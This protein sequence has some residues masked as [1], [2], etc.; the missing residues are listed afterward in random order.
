MKKFKMPS[1]YTILFLIIIIIALLTWIVPSGEYYNKC[2]SGEEALMYVDPETGVENNVCPVSKQAALEL[3]AALTTNA[4]V[5]SSL[6]TTD[7]E[8]VYTEKEA[9]PQGIW[10]VLSAPINGFYDAVDI[11]LFVLIIGGFINVVM[12]TGALTEGINALL[13]KFK[14]REHFLIPILMTLFALLGT[15]M[16]M[17][18]ETIAFYLL[19]VPIFYQA[20]YDTI[21]GVK[22]ILLGAGVGVLASTVNPFAIGVASAAAGTSMGDG[23][24][25]RTLLWVILLAVAIAYTMR[26]AHKVKTDPSKSIVYDLKE[27]HQKEFVQK[28]ET[29]EELTIHHKVILALFVSSFIVMVLSVIPWENFGVT[30]FATI[31]T[32]INEQMTVLSGIDGI[33]ILGAWW[34]GELTTLFLTFAIIV[35]IYATKTKILKK[36]FISAF[37]AGA[38]DLLPVALIVG[39]S[40]GIQVVMVAGGMDATLLYYGSQS[41]Q[42]LG[43]VAFSI[44]SFIFYIPMSFL[45]PSTSGLAGATIPVMSPLGNMIFDS[46]SGSI[47]VITGY[48]M[49]S[50]I[51]N[52][53]T[54][55]SGVVMGGLALARVP[56][57]RWLK[58]MIPFI[59]LLTIICII[60]LTIT[61]MTGF[62]L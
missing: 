14:N 47:Q 3:N 52:L 41:L 42:N 19:I 25:G 18:E 11:G 2:S 48:I 27:E 22:V 28:E 55:T 8:Y 59:I 23:I 60:F 33:P 1:S 51:V 57:D 26:Y 37:I 30:I 61:T 54:P 43:E 62:Y 58:H 5:D 21:T 24:V 13:R 16:G 10:A 46:G 29:R 7:F 45:I 35:G 9:H 36:D 40:R 56:Y 4:A 53:I 17:A 38:V 12:E 6:Y 32:F 34:F 31:G 15:T 44:F 49:A 39:L 20:G 50:G